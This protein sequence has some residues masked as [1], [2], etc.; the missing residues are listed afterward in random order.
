MNFA[1]KSP[2]TSRRQN[3]LVE[4]FDFLLRRDLRPVSPGDTVT[5]WPPLDIADLENS[6]E[7]KVDLPGV[8]KD[9]IEVT[10][11]DGVLA[12]TAETKCE[13]RSVERRSI[14]RERRQGRYERR[15]RVGDGVDEK[16][17]A[18]EYRDGVLT[19]SLPKVARVLPRKITVEA[20]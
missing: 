17:V 14:R 13:E 6:Y 3:R 20:H 8:M 5:F 18:A 15:L 9:D 4:E 19:V 16:A 11:H 2:I 7:I 1:H 10:V 12:L